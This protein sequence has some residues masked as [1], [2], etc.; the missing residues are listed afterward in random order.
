[1]SH[2]SKTLD[3]GEEQV[4]KYEISSTD[5]IKAAK[6]ACAFHDIGKADRRYQNYLVCKNGPRIFHPLLGL[7][8][9]RDIAESLDNEM[10]KCLAV[11]SVAS[12]HTTLHQELYSGVEEDSCYLRVANKNHFETIIYELAKRIGIDNFDVAD[13]YTKNSRSVLDQVKM[14]LPLISDFE[15]G[16]RL[17]EYF[18]EIQGILNYS[19]WLASGQP[20]TSHLDLKENFILNPYHYQVKARNTYGNVFITLPT[21][22]GKTETAL[23]W[24]SKNLSPGFRAFYTL[25]TTTTINA[26]YQRLIDESRY[27]LNRNVV[28]EYFSNVDL[29]L[30]LEGLNPTKANLTLYRNFFYPLNVTT[31]D[32]LI[33]AMMNHGRYS[34][35][36]FLMKKSLVI[37]D[38]IH[39]YDSETFGLIKSLI[40]HLH[41]HYETKFCIMSATFPEI[42]KKELSFLNADELIHRS[43]LESEYKKRRR[44]RIEFSDSFIIKNLHKIIQFYKEEIYTKK[45]KRKKR[46]LIVMNTVRRAQQIFALLQTVMEQNNYPSNDLML[47]HSRFRFADRRTLEKR[48]FEYPRIVVA[49]QLI[50]VSLDIDYDVLFTEACYPDSLVQRAGRINRNGDLGNSGEGLINVFLPEGHRPYE[51]RMLND[52]IKLIQEKAKKISSE[53]DYIRLTNEFYDRSWQSSQDA[54]ERFETIWTIVRYIYRANLSEDRMI[55]LLRTRSGLL[56]INSYSRTHLERILSLD[57]AISSV[58][59]ESI[60]KKLDLQ[61][62]IRMYSINVPVVESVKFTHVPGMDDREYVIVEADYDP[63]LGLLTEI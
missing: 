10:L 15:D 18:V 24:I 59:E 28:S 38:E 49:T 8:V 33:L 6:I 45:G 48:I 52:S 36:S 17:R 25:P 31:P 3:Y 14:D 63:R 32:Q 54:E 2:L 5:L 50:E 11:L 16:V 39:A 13:C 44:T 61:R 22:S 20:E 12:H 57:R 19:D 51:C 35:K 56:T 29:Y 1:L 23:S 9:V 7:P 58:K 26:M 53:M 21:G 4:R 41:D 30:E 46:I 55:E 47:L 34:L 62:Q 27:G 42:L 40:K 43:V 60:E 37:F